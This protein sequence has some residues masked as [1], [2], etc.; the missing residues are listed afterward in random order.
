MH[1][2]L[3]TYGTGDGQTAT[4]ARE[5]ATVLADRGFDVTTRT[6]WDT[7]DVAVE[8]FDGVVI[9]ASVRNRRHQPAIVAFVERNRQALA[10]RPSGFFQ[11]SFLS[12]LPNAWAQTGAR[13]WVDALVAATGWQPDHVGVFGGA[14]KYTQYNPVT[15]LLFRLA[16]TVTTGDTDTSRDYEYT[17]WAAVEQF[18]VEFGDLVE[19]RRGRSLLAAAGEKAG[20]ALLVFGLAAVGY[21]LSSRGQRPRQGTLTE[22]DGEAGQPA[23][24]DESG[25]A[26]TAVD[27]AE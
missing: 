7:D 19:R 5:I 8:D 24:N 20:A 23:S 10:A 26:D 9:G 11:V 2:V 12:A 14:V 1:S 15:R 18:A 17:D 3:V 22:F 4:V 6:V 27:A 21:W 25:G 13:E 16:A